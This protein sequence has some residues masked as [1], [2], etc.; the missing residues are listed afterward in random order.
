MYNAEPKAGP[1]VES[2]M[3]LLATPKDLR[4]K[5]NFAS[6]FQQLLELKREF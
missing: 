2:F 1:K 4:Q 5:S 6:Y 3:K